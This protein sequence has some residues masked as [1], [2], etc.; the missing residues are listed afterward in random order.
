M[1]NFIDEIWIDG[2]SQRQNYYK[3]E[4][5]LGGGRFPIKYIHERKFIELEKQ[6]IELEAALSELWWNGKRSKVPISCGGTLE[7][8]TQDRLDKYSQAEFAD[9]ILEIRKLRQRVDELEAKLGGGT[10]EEKKDELIT[11]LQNALFVRDSQLKDLVQKGWADNS[12]SV[13][14]NIEEKEII[15]LGPNLA[16]LKGITSGNAEIQ[17]EHFYQFGKCVRCNQPIDFDPE[18]TPWRGG[19]VKSAAR[20]RDN[21]DKAITLQSRNT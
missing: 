17:C 5:L 4:L 15:G 6:V 12:A 14:G 10:M 16:K 21:E 2:N 19:W 9:K 13:S 20:R 3:L 11:Q 18:Y 7:E 1:N 8:T